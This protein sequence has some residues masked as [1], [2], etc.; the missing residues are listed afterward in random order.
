MQH[1]YGQQFAEIY[2]DVFPP[3]PDLVE[4]LASSAPATALELG[5]GTGRVAIPLAQRGIT[6]TGVDLSA[7]ML[8]RCR[9]GADDAGVDLELVQGSMTDLRLGR[10]FDLVF[11]VCASISM[12]L[13]REH[14]RET[15]ATARD[16]LADGGRLVVETHNPDAV[17]GLHGGRRRE[18]WFVPYPGAGRGLQTYA[19]LDEPTGLWQVSHLW[20]DGGRTTIGN[21]VSLLT[22]VEVLTGLG[23]ELGLAVRSVTGDRNGGP[24][25]PESPTYTVEFEVA[26]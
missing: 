1:T 12:L 22:P 24:V 13:T 19:T 21:E 23:A 6:V 16:H 25:T 11:C 20:H 7:E 18:T 3:D 10:R 8:D 9:D 26:S 15:L 17:L 2:D 14:Q 5:V 4:V